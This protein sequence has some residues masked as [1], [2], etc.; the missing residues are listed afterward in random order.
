MVS[1]G[2]LAVG[3]GPAV[4]PACGK[5]VPSASRRWVRK[6]HRRPAVGRGSPIGVPP[7]V[8]CGGGVLAVARGQRPRITM[9]RRD[10]STTPALKTPL[11]KV[12]NFSE[13][14][15]LW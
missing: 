10:A 8:W 5:E 9:R 1:D 12:R 15:Y 4:R 3:G 6:S 13:R 11:S 14:R 7:L 2:I